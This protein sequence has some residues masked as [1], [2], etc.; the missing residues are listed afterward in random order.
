MQLSPK[1]RAV[2]MLIAEGYSYAQIVDGHSEIS[3]RDI[4]QAAEE[5]LQLDGSGGNYHGRMAEIKKKYPK[6]YE[7]WTDDEKEEL[8]AMHASRSSLVAI[9]EKL[10]RQPSAIR[11][12]LDKLG[13][14]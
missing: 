7:P 5:A 1:S 8:R 6:A 12:Q 14:K 10:R 11:S 9:A 2:L 4:F 13:L 3:Y